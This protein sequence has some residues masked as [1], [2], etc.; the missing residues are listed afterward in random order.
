MTSET[1]D[2]N[3]SNN[4][5]TAAV[6]L[7]PEADLQ[8][9]KIA[10]PGHLTAG[11]H[12]AYLI[13]VH[14]AGPS[15]ATEVTV[16]DPI[17]LGLNLLAARPSQGSC[18]IT[19]GLRCELGLLAP[20][21]NAVILAVAQVAPNAGGR[22]PNT[23]TVTGGEVDPNPE[24]NSSTAI[25]E[26]DPL[27]PE[28]L[29][30]E[31]PKP[32][33]AGGAPGAA[34]SKAPVVKGAKTQALADLGVVKQVDRGVTRVGRMLTYTVRVTNHGPDEAVGV[35]LT[36]SWTRALR[37]VSVRTSRGHCDEGAPL[38]CDLG[39]M[40]SGASASIL[41]KARVLKAGHERNTA[42]VASDSRDPDLS[43][44]QSAV[45]TLVRPKPSPPPPPPVVT[46]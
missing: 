2:P 39:N 28:P 5:D 16:T 29:E 35:H 15:T 14:N 41:I 44:N 9:R 32:A 26:V 11:G 17:P 40:K 10:L 8:I 27:T 38:Q 13:A 24:D 1:P 31:S 34:P 3:P 19:Y 22:V 20:D 46:G 37:I 21:G 18:Q 45:E 23:A 7:L 42:V 6:P 36:D 25:V 43:N 12:V 33:E 30:P 4:E